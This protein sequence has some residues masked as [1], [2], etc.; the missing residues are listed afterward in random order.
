MLHLVEVMKFLGV[1]ARGKIQTDSS[2]CVGMASRK[3]VGRV[4]H[5]EAR[6]L[7]LQGVIDSECI[8]MKKIPGE[9][10]LGDVGTKN[11]E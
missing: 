11:F 8:G 7:W 4:R 1:N 5:L 3:G 10:N 6:A 2:A 9:K